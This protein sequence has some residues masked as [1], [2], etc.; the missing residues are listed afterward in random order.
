M[1]RHIEPPQAPELRGRLEFHSYPN[2][3]TTIQ[4]EPGSAV[5]LGCG[6]KHRYDQEEDVFVWT[7]WPCEAHEDLEG[8][9]ERA[10]DASWKELHG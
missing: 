10:F 7:S 6:C 9:F 8:R 3:T 1:K 2:L 5:I 4:L